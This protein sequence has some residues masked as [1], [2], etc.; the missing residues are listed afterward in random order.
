MQSAPTPLSSTYRTSKRVAPL[1]NQALNKNC[2]DIAFMIC[3]N[4]LTFNIFNKGI[5]GQVE[6]IKTLNTPLIAV[7]AYIPPYLF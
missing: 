5:I 6:I 3:L 1:E 2:P 4:F 7:C